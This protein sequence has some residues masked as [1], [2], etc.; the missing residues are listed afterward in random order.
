MLDR[1]VWVLARAGTANAGRRHQPKQR[2][3]QVVSRR[4]RRVRVIIRSSGARSELEFYVHQW[5]CP[6]LG[7]FC[8]ACGVTVQPTSAPCETQ[9]ICSF[10][11]SF[12]RM[13]S[14]LFGQ[15]PS[16]RLWCRRCMA[17]CQAQ[18]ARRL[19]ARWRRESTRCTATE[20]GPCAGYAACWRCRLTV[21]RILAMPRRQPNQHTG[22]ARSGIAS[23]RV[24]PAPTRR[25]IPIA[26]RRVHSVPLWQFCCQSCCDGVRAS[27]TSQCIVS[28]VASAARGL[29]LR[30]LGTTLH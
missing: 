13:R 25:M 1:L 10:A 30:A 4:P 29:G 6:K 5:Y 18:P 23:L 22:G 27:R 17:S 12:T 21:T 16:A 11:V 24:P 2:D 14:Q 9:R 3:R 8:V 20:A 19:F 28:C 26:S 7:Q 15:K